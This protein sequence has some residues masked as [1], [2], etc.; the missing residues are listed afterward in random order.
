MQKGTL[1]MQVIIRGQV[2]GVFFRAFIAEKANM[3]NIK[4]YVRNT[5]DRSVEAL[6]QGTKSAI[7]QMLEYCKQGPPR[8]EVEDV[9]IIRETNLKSFKDFSITH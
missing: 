2:Q 6:F 9:Q 3:L 8:S 4:G 5:K 1:S 7:K